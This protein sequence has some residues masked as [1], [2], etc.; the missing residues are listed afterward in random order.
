MEASVGKYDIGIAVWASQY[1]TFLYDQLDMGMYENV[2]NLREVDKIPGWHLF[3]TNYKVRVNGENYEAIY[4]VK[5]CPPYNTSW[6]I[7]YENGSIVP[8]ETIY[9]H[10]AE[11]AAVAHLV[12]CGVESE[13]LRH[14][15][16]IMKSFTDYYV[17]W[18]VGNCSIKGGF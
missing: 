12:D 3:A 7:Q 1:D 18:K 2:F 15:Q 6:L 13:E 5:N 16:G 10:A 4:A 17:I 8:N 14:I 11:A 9:K